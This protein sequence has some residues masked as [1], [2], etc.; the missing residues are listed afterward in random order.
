LP[1][2]GT[3]VLPSRFMIMVCHLAF[4]TAFWDITP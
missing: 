2:A 3:P 1:I 4:Q